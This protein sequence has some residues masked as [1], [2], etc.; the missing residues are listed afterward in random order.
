MHRLKRYYD[1][2]HGYADN[3]LPTLFMVERRRQ[4][5][6]ITKNCGTTQ[7]LIRRGKPYSQAVNRFSIAPFV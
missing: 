1:S 3:N 4:Q 5:Y 7:F 6:R 2:V